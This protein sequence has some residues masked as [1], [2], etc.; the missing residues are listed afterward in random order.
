MLSGNSSDSVMN[1]WVSATEVQV[2]RS[3]EAAGALAKVAQSSGAATQGLGSLANAFPEAPQAGGGMSWLS[4]L[5]MPNFVPNG[6][7]ATIAA[8]GGIGLYDSGGYTGPGGKM[9]PAGIVHKGEYVFDAESVRRLGVPNLERLRGY[10]SGG[11]VGAPVA[12][13][14]NKRQSID[15]GQ[16]T[17]RDL[18]VNVS[19]ASGDPHVRELVRQGVQEALAAD[20]EQQ[21]RGGFGNMQS[22]FAS[23]KG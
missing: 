9:T 11:M 4:K 2:R 15:T 1:S 20:R 10:A 8:G 13:R 3:T 7:Q 12:P 22:K 6:A 21:R 16:N 18:N 5:F 14:L 19:G 17:P 23:Q